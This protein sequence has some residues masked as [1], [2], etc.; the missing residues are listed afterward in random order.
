MLMYIFL[1]LQL[2]LTCFQAV[3]C[4]WPDFPITFQEKKTRFL[5]LQGITNIENDNSNT[6]SSNT[7]LCQF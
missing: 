1:V 6:F 4:D 5:S 3:H 2:V 7:T